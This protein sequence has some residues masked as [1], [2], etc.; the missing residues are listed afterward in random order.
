MYLITNRERLALLLET[1]RIA[2]GGGI[3]PCREIL[4]RMKEVLYACAPDLLDTERVPASKGKLGEVRWVNRVRWI[5]K[6]FEQNGYYV[7]AP[8]GYWGRHDEETTAKL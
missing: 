3:Q 7:R 1:T 8:K 5:R 6:V 4:A 2:M